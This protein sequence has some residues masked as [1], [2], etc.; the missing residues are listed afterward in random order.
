MKVEDFYRQH[1]C[2]SPCLVKDCDLPGEPHH[3]RGKRLGGALSLKPSDLSGIPL[4]Y[5]HHNELHIIGIESFEERHGLDLMRELIFCLWGF[6]EWFYKY[7]ED[8]LDEDPA[9]EKKRS[10][11]T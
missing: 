10:M 3:L 8:P 2:G 7:C 4:C 11:A 5:I 6:I 1:I 9:Q